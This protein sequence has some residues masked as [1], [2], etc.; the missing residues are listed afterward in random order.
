MP[1]QPRIL[2]ADDH[3]MVAAG[4]SLLL[5]RSFDLVATVTDGAELVAA[6]RRLVPDVVV[7]DISMPVLSGIG[8]LRQLKA[9]A[10]PS[11]VVF[12]TMHAEASL[13]IE[14]LR[15]GA[16]GYLVKH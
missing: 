7:A 15:A 9:D 16:S 5:G 11:R 2:L 13:A 10:I 3:A 12:V 6:A 1:P 8:A 14:A 4:L